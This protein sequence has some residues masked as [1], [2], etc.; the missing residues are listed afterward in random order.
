MV[1]LTNAS[2]V[3]VAE[4]L[5]FTFTDLALYGKATQD[6]FPLF[7]KVFLTRRRSAFPGVDYSGPVSPAPALANSAYLGTYTNN[8]FGDVQIIEKGDGLAIVEGPHNWTLILQHYDRDTFTCQT[9]AKMRSARPASLL[10]S[11]RTEKPPP[12]SLKT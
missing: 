6:W 9:K 3:G 7:K 12:W 1:V 11:A 10:P 8:F 5:A 4:G 2:P